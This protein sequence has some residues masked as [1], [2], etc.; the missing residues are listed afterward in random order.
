MRPLLVLNKSLL[1]RGYMVAMLGNKHISF[2]SERQ[3]RAR[4]VFIFIEPLE[5]VSYSLK[6]ESLA[7]QR[8]AR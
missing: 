5:A 1:E 3:G 8:A 6:L 7:L 2:G 4:R